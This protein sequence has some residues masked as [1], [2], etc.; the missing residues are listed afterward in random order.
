MLQICELDALDSRILIKGDSLRGW[1][2]ARVCGVILMG[3]D[4]R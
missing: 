4:W 2:N 1:T 3:S